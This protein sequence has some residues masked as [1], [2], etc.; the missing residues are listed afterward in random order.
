MVTLSGTVCFRHWRPEHEAIVFLAIVFLVS[1][2]SQ[3]RHL[4]G[5]FSA[6]GIKARLVFMVCKTS[7]D[8][9]RIHFFNSPVILLTALCLLTETVLQP[10]RNVPALGPL[11]LL[12]PLRGIKDPMMET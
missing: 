8:L 3:R 5:N 7:C 4:P 2:Y 1:I 6:T 10:A 11:H 12:F 9:A